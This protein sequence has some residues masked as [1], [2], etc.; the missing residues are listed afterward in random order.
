MRADRYSS[1]TQWGREIDDA[2]ATEAT[3]GLTPLETIAE[4]IA[5]FFAET[6]E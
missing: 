3:G 6:E 1:L 4:Q 2:L 5:P